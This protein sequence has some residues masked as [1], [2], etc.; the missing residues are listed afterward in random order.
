M[1]RIIAFILLILPFT[2]FAQVNPACY[3]V[4]A[5]RDFSTSTI[6]KI[7]ANDFAI[8]P[9][10]TPTVGGIVVMKYPNAWHIATITS[11]EETGFWVVDG[12]F[13]PCE[14]TRHFIKWDNPAIYKFWNS[15]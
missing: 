6:P 11:L 7:N 1:R 9:S 4:M 15:G 3:C 13:R 8:F 14:Y 10:K 2:V 5:A 12:N